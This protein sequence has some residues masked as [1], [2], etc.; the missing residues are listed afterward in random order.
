[1]IG[2]GSSPR[3][4]LGF[5][6]IE[7]PSK[8]ANTAETPQ[9]AISAMATTAKIENVYSPAA[10]R[11]NPIGNPAT[12]TNVPASLGRAVEAEAK[13]PACSFS[14]PLFSRVTI[15]SIVIIGRRPQAEGDDQGT[16]RDPREIDPE[17]SECA[18]RP[19]QQRHGRGH[20]S[21]VF[22]GDD[23]FVPVPQQ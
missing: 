19:A 1:M 11:A 2:P 12:V 6:R 23:A 5:F 10:L 4:A 7:T 21:F 16:Q 18:R 20:S 14:S 17:K 15:A 22:F 13:M 9:D 3:T 8:G